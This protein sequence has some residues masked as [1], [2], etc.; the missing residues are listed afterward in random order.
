MN[1]LAFAPASKE[2]AKA[3]IS[4]DG[5]SGSGKTWT[6]L[7]I[8]TVLAGGGKVALIDTERGS[9]SK[10]SDE[11]TF[12]TLQLHTFEPTVLVQAL[13]SAAAANY[14]AVIVDSLSHFWMGKGGMLQQVDNAAKRTGG[15]SFAGWKDARPLEQAMIDALLAYPGHVIVTMRTKTEW[16]VEQNDRGKQVPRRVGTKPEQRDGIEYEFDIVGDLDLDNT[17][18]VTKTRCKS[19]SGA[20][21]RKPGEEFAQEILAWLS[22]GKPAPTASDYRAQALSDKATHLGMR[23]LYE[24]AKARNL[25]GA[26]VMDS[27]GHPTT[28]GDLIVTRGKALEASHASN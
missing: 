23:A 17:L 2:Q 15:N 8:A 11:F 13:A 26:A 10:Y 7:A 24:D 20:V 12:D 25:L 6:A 19:L 5:P 3:R 28:L 16:V 1:A 22:D 18:V 14:P 4:L 9:A 21:V 27:D